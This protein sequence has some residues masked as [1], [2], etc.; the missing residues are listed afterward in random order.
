MRALPIFHNH[1][2]KLQQMGLE[3][4]MSTDQVSFVSHSRFFVV[5]CFRCDAANFIVALTKKIPFFFSN[6]QK[7]KQN[8][9]P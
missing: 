5:A 8:N 6:K 3:Q 2:G 1:Y 9:S 4:K 7:R